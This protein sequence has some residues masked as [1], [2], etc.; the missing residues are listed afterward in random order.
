M[1][2]MERSTK[3]YLAGAVL[4]LL[5]GV[6]LYSTQAVRWEAQALVR[7]AQTATGQQN[8]ITSE[9]NAVEDVPVV[10]ERL[11]S[12]S[13]MSEV[14]KRAK[15]DGVA[16]ILN[17]DKCNCLT[18]KLIKNND[19]LII[20]V[21]GNT[22]ELAK[23]SADAVVEE[24]KFKHSI[25]LDNYKSGIEHKALALDRETEALSKNIA[26]LAESMQMSKDKADDAQAVS[27][28]ILIMTMQA[29]L[30]KKRSQSVGLRDLMSS[31]YSRGT[32]LLEP[33]FVREKRLF[34]SLWRACLFGTLLGVFFSVLW[35]RWG[36]YE[37]RVQL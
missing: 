1:F 20:S 35:V 9:F 27:K 26:V 10:I 33:I 3:V 37:G 34:S 13:F 23:I 6:L 4:G 29:D 19:A 22:P 18:I 17:Q 5:F 15:T 14:V 25:L 2:N 12:R 30:E 28:G 8:Q 36:K 24:L 32:E 7:L 21:V 16:D 11:K 31:F